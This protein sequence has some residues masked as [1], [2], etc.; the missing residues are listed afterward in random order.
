LAGGGVTAD[1]DAW[2][3]FDGLLY[4][5]ITLKPATGAEAT[6]E[7][8]DVDFPMAPSV[9]VQL[10][11]NGGG[12]DFRSSWVA[13]P[14]PAA[15]GSVWN[16]LEKP[17][18]AFGRAFEVN[19]FMP[20]IWLGNDDVGLYFGAENDQGWTVDG[21]K[22]AQ[23]ILRQEGAVIVRLNV[24]REPTRIEAAGRRFH[25][26]LLPTPAKPE[27]S[28]WRKQMLGGVN[29]GSCDTFG[30]FDM[31]T[32]PADPNPGDAFR[33]E[34]R[35]WDHAAKQAPQCRAKWGRCILY[36]DMSWPGFG[37]SFRDWNHDLHAGT[38]RLAIFPEMEDYMVWA[39]NEFLKRG[40]IDGVYWDDVSVG[41]TYSLASTA[42][43]YAGS[44]NGR[45][46]GFTALAQR[47]V[48][49]R[50][51]RLFE[52][53]GREPCIWA[54]MTVC[55]E[56][57]LF[58]FCRYLS[59]CEFVTGVD[60][61]G[62][63]DA[64]DMWSPDTLRLLGGS[65]KWGTG[66]HNLSTLPR[67]LPDSAVAKQWSYPQQRTETGLYLTSD[68]WGPPDG[69]GQV[70]VRE[71]VL[72]G[73]VRA[74]PWWKSTEVVTVHAPA[75]SAVRA[76]AYVAGGRVVVIVANWDREERDVGIELNPGAIPG[77][78]AGVAWRDLDPG[79]KPPAAVAASA[80]E[81]G[82]AAAAAGGTAPGAAEDAAD[83]Q[84]LND[85]LDGT[86]HEERA[87]KRLELRTEGPRARVAIRPRDYR[88]LEAKTGR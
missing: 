82:K 74:Y 79:L 62:K 5:A 12:S 10:L 69:L 22:P 46:V 72:E 67:A 36:A 47:R 59:N 39:V 11:A 16:S 13:K 77:A 68:Q 26:V 53:A 55:Y 76:G 75:G 83:E 23:E 80:A 1:L 54:H 17:Y 60:F 44:A 33:L 4:C 34:P 31:K 41:Y 49:M 64:M 88:V 9:A 58:S 66:Y 70:L 30:G 27:P 6:L 2:M 3:E 86:T 71:K 50:L 40:L 14:V 24:I 7:D 15:N 42:Y 32:D 78:G 43:E 45:R 28:D 18:P 21:P 63:R 48:N 61:P 35:S 85:L 20:N 8:L 81:I 57:P 65:S 52:A 29:F 84:E 56:V 87:M 25:F 73:P 38:G 37:P 19:N 51:W